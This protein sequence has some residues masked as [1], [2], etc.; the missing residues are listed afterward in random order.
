MS[1]CILSSDDCDKIWFFWYNVL[2]FMW[3]EANSVCSNTYN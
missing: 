2:V 1:K 3:L